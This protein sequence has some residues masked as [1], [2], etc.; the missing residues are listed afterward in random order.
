MNKSLLYTFMTLVIMFA[1]A[2]ENERWDNH[3]RQSDARLSVDLLERIKSDPDLSTFAGYLE[4]TGYDTVLA[5]NQA[6]TVWAPDNN[7]FS[8]YS[9]STN[10]SNPEALSAL[11]ANH[12]SMFSYTSAHGAQDNLVKVLNNKYIKYIN[13][14]TSRTFADA[15]V[16]LDDILCSNGILHEIDAVAEVRP[17][18]WGYLQNSSE[19]PLMMTYLDQFNKVQ[20]DPQSSVVIGQNSLGQPVYDSVFVVANSYFDIVGDL[21]SEE[22]RY[23]FMALTDEVY[24]TAFDTISTYYSHPDT[25]VVVSNTEAT[26]YNNLNFNEFTVAGITGDK[27]TNTIGNS[28]EVN[29]STIETSMNLSNGKLFILNDYTF[30]VRDLIYKPIRYEVENTKRRFISNISELTIQK[31]YKTNASGL[32]TNKIAYIGDSLSY[33][34]NNY[35]EVKFSE[36][37]SADYDLYVK[38]SNIGNARKTFITYDIFVTGINEETG[39]IS[40]SVY[41]IPEQI[42]NPDEDN[43]IK[44][45]ESF[46]VPIYIDDNLNNSYYVKVRVQIAVSE[47]QSI[48]YDQAVGID[49]L[50]LVPAE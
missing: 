44:I 28:L 12:I 10:L 2:C 22:N 15:T 5:Q 30:D 41:T 37:L 6:Y 16:I 39:E 7:A 25:Q 27:I 33:N 1:S 13:T 31:I 48:L 47:A 35:F 19:F 24:A 29:A 46:N 36:V 23:S 26:I 9:G 38:Y 14:G 21:N 49:Y 45:G 17:N 4:Q 42:V 50:E 18:I 8:N 43:R 34:V 20:F 11:I 3:Y 40:E 32:F